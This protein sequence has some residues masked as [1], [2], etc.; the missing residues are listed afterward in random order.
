MRHRF[1]YG[2]HNQRARFFRRAGCAAA[3]VLTLSLFGALSL[4]RVALSGLGIT[5]SSVFL[6]A[7]AIGLAGM[8]VIFAA[9]LRSFALP[10]REIM[11][12]AERVA[13][14]DYTTRVRS[15]GPPPIRNLAAA[16]NTMTERL[17]TNDAQ[18]RQLMADVSHELRTPLTI[19]QG[20]L[21]GLLDGVYPRDETHLADVLEETRVLS[22]LVEDLR[23][24]ALSEAG[25]LNLQKEA[26]DLAILVHEVVRAFEAEADAKR[27]T[28]QAEIPADLPLI[29]VDP[30]RIREVLTNLVSNALR[31]TPA[32]GR[33]TIAISEE[34]EIRVENTGEGIAPE[35]LERIFDRFYKG[36]ESRGSG[37]GLTIAKNLVEAH[38]G[39]IRA[40]SESGEGTVIAFTLR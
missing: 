40:T 13:E 12:A 3:L 24:L 29:D 4:A 25:A 26:T 20:R 18:R 30:I 28:L 32:G 36:S 38:G 34:M 37:L 35:E 9:M 15:S 21:E 16:F 31:H 27:V 19:M 5:S 11:D 17:G 23:T 33:V 39:R 14:G 8:L 7:A 22:R 2:P 10:L 1:G 6:F